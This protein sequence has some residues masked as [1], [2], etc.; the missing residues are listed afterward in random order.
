MAQFWKMYVTGV[1]LA[2][3][4][5]PHMIQA[6][7]RAP[8]LIAP[9]TMKR[10]GTVD[11]RYQS[12][13]VEMLEVTGGKFWKPYTEIGKSTAQPAG[14]AGVESQQRHTRRNER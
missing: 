11:E 5:M 1:A 14:V 13:N 4:V 2:L 10:I 12:Y 3:A 7:D 6:Q 9:A 8:I